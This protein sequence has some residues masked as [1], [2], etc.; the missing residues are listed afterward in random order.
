MADLFDLYLGALQVITTVVAAIIFI[1]SLDEL[2][3]DV[4][5]LFRRLYRRF[6]VFGLRAHQPLRARDLYQ[7]PEQPIAVLVPAWHEE[8]VIERMLE[9]TCRSF[10]YDNYKIYVGVYQND[11]ATRAAVTAVAQRFGRIEIIT[12]EHDGPT[13]K[14]D[15]LNSI[16]AAI[17]AST[18]DAD[19]EPAIYVVHDAEDVVHPLALKLF[20]FLIPRKDMVQLPVIALERPWHDFTGGHY[21]DE[22]AENHGK[23]LLVRE[24]L[25][26][27]V[28][29]AGVGC[30]FSRRALKAVATSREGAPFNIKSLTEDYD[31]ALT[32][33]H[34]G[35]SQIFVRFAITRNGDHRELVA[36]REFFPNTF[37]A[38]RRQKARWLLGIV[39]QSFAD[40][41]WRGPWRLKYALFRDRKGGFTAFA[42]VGGYVVAATWSGFYIAHWLTSGRF[43]VPPLAAYHSI[44]W[45]LLILNAGLL[46]NRALHRACFTA[47]LYGWRQGLA[48]LPRQVWANVINCAAASRAIAL[49][50]RHRL[51]GQPLA[52]DKT[53]HAFPTAHQLRPFEE[54]LGRRLVAKGALTESALT[55][56][57]TRQAKLRAQPLGQVLLEQGAI[58]ERVLHETLAEQLDRKRAS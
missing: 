43:A 28:P 14:A 9:H 20:N 17:T 49:Y 10:D 53:E 40:N 35:F 12:V 41:G 5:F 56:A 27:S 52:W 32:M 48:S 44:T 39:F 29:A 4:I 51:S 24:W 11:P 50:V 19:K 1:S 54:R 42:A 46:L 33:R 15:C 36:T 3:Y 26:G 16:Y 34:A 23:D 30:G 6:I 37:A 47:A 45:W 55:Q 7:W 58:S 31:L 13:N 38:A 22:F 18:D 25:S 2:I 57:L 8:A 21:M